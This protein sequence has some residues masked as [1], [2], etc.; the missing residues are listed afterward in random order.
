MGF[1]GA[2]RRC[3]VGTCGLGA[4]GALAAGVVPLGDLTP[5][6]AFPEPGQGQHHVCAT[7]QLVADRHLTFSFVDGSIDVDDWHPDALA[8]IR[9]FLPKWAQ[10][11]SP[12]GAPY[13]DVYEDPDPTPGDPNHIFI[14]AAG[15]D[16]LAR[17][18]CDNG[19]TPVVE[20]NDEVAETGVSP[21]DG[22]GCSGD[23]IQQGH[24]YE[25]GL[26]AA[27]EFG[28]WFELTHAPTLNDLNFV[29]GGSILRSPLM[30]TADSDKTATLAPRPDDH[31]SMHYRWNAVDPTN[32]ASW[33]HRIISPNPG[34]ER[35]M[36][37]W[38]W[39]RGEST[40]TPPETGTSVL[41]VTPFE[42]QRLM[43]F[44]PD[45]PTERVVT[46][47]L[48]EKRAGEAFSLQTYVAVRSLEATGVPYKVDTYVAEVSWHSNL[49]ADQYFEY[50]LAGREKGVDRTSGQM[51]KHSGVAVTASASAWNPYAYF[52]PGSVFGDDLPVGMEGMHVRNVIYDA[53][54]DLA[55]D[56]FA[57]GI[58]GVEQ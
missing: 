54:G 32:A 29:L 28:H 4:A 52:D 23:P 16:P 17:V 57:P 1:E 33:D 26:L 30:A 53:T 45:D 43:Y 42:G 35:G 11:V 37:D 10:V 38:K 41:G 47:S 58:R 34:F 27:H 19:T 18:V 21:S 49:C 5:A 39:L 55:V 25:M 14:R 3:G 13:F 6:G 15:I 9:A 56:R 48:V 46:D 12:R 40:G 22:E 50:S 8:E 20:F 7:P 2:W 31:A 44:H 51:V 24:D 36:T